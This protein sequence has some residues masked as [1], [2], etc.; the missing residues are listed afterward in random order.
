M[1]HRKIRIPKDSA[2][3]VMEVIGNIDDGVQFVDLNKNDYEQKKNFGTLITRCE[4][5]NKRIT[6]FTN[7]CETRKI[8]INKYKSYKTFKIDLETD[9]EN[10]DKEKKYGTTYFD[11]LENQL[12]EDE[13]QMTVLTETYQKITDNLNALIE[14]KSVYDKISQLMNNSD[15]PQQTEMS[16]FNQVND[17]G[18]NLID[19]ASNNDIPSESHILKHFSSVQSNLSFVSGVINAADANRFKRMIFRVSRGRAITTFF[20]LIIE[21]STLNIKQ[22]KKIFNVFYQSSIM[23]SEDYLKRKILNICD[24]LGASKYE[25][26]SSLAEMTKSISELNSEINDKRS[27]LHVCEEQIHK[28]ISDKIGVDGVPAKYEMYRLYFLQQRF[29]FINL[30]KCK[31][32]GNFIDGEVWIPED[33]I[34]EVEEEVLKIGKDDPNKLTAIFTKF[35]NEDFERDI[36]SLDYDSK[37][38]TYFKLN[39]FTFPFQLIVSEYGMPR[40]REANPGIFTI[41]TFP[42]MFGVMFGDIGHGL[43]LSLLGGFMVLKHEDICKNYPAFKS[44]QKAR[45]LF[46]F[47]GLFAF[48]NGWMY[49]DF[50]SMPLGIFG[51]CYKNVENDKK[52]VTVVRKGKCVYPFGMD[53]KW[54]VA[55]NDLAFVNSLKMKTSVILGIIQMILGIILKGMNDYYYKNYINIVF[56]FIP[57]IVFMVLLFGY[58]ILMI[59]VKWGIDWSSDPSKAPS[60]ISQLLLIFL[61]MGSVGPD[62]NKQP[63]FYR[64]D[65]KIQE[66]LQYYLLI[67]SVIC[68]PIM[69]FPKPILKVILK[70]SKKEVDEGSMNELNEINLINPEIV[71]QHSE[72]HHKEEGFTDLFVHQT[73]ETIEFVLGAVSNTASY[74][75][76]W[77]LSLA[78]AQLSKVFFEITLLGFIQNGSVVGMFVGFLLLSHITLGVLMGMD[79]ME[80]FLHTLRLHWVEFQNKFFKADGVP[81]KPFSFKYIDDEFI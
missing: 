41:I 5:A 53:P 1:S 80:C 36:E 15:R 11:M 28:F 13:K 79:L 57:Q 62:D 46:L 26:P 16:L 51:S 71:N 4:E 70:N 3:E 31:M 20:D 25:I 74:L 59:F 42:F 44:A 47:L 52:E 32:I 37:P 50:L 73:I 69:W 21:N 81:F 58:M 48:Y 14:Q 63:I 78:H 40:Y 10:V 77:A 7:L 67:I 29:I 6:K 38:P 34:N 27:V 66:N 17:M 22:E 56:E 24:M 19:S 61:N 49:D 75:R 30:N 35:E 8:N 55:Q 12:V 43:L 68:V 18:I 72:E 60:I 33:K 65:Y 76:L 54:N 39:D 64:H 45:Y 23:T 2:M 9:K